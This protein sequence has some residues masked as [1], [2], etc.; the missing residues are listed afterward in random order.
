MAL[1]SSE[2]KWDSTVLLCI[3]LGCAMKPC[4]GSVHVLSET[5][6][7]GTYGGH[8]MGGGDSSHSFIIFP[9]KQ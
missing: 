6:V 9:K 2:R 8:G 7:L 1:W 3:I 4:T 5:N